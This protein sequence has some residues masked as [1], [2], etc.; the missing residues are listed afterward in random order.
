M[1]NPQSYN[2]D[3]TFVAHLSKIGDKGELFRQLNSVLEL[4]DYFGYNWDALSDCLR[5]FHWIEQQRI[6][7]VHDACPELNEQEFTTYLKILFEAVQ[8]WKEGD[9]HYIEIVFP[10]Q[11][12]DLVQQYD[13]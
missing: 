6:V 12:K 2:P 13:L 8:D 11:T 10:E 4:P 3:A 7:L 1:N 5:D 9:D